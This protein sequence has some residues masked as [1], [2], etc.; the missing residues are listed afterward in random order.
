MAG[1]SSA[2]CSIISKRSGA[3]RIRASGRCARSRCTSRYSK[4][5]AWVAFDRALKSAEMFGL[6]GPVDH[7][8][9][10][11]AEIHRGCLREGHGTRS[12]ARSCAPTAPRTST[13]ACCCCAPIGFLKPD[14]PRYRATVEAV[15][16]QP[17]VGRA[18]AA[19]RHRP[20]RGRP[21]AGEGA[22]LP[23]SFWLADAYLLIGR[24]PDAEALFRRLAR[25]L[26]RCRPAGRGVRPARQAPARQLSAG[27]LPHRA[28]EHRL[29]PH[30]PEKPAEQRSELPPG[31]ANHKGAKTAAAE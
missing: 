18:A 13:R 9:E 24:R 23:C 3:S 27:V 6:P 7:W 12:L 16:R 29:Q 19:L 20:H 25:A 28:G 15:E 31:T 1:T 17:D 14:D 2:P 8:R 21:A 4:V 10:L 11:C 26:Q 30:A 5:M 22:F